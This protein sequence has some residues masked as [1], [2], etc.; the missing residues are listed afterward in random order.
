MGSPIASSE[1]RSFPRVHLSAQHRP[2]LVPLHLLV[3]LPWLGPSETPQRTLRGRPTAKLLVALLWVWM[4]PFRV[5]SRLSP[6][7][8]ALNDP[9]SPHH[10]DASGARLSRLPS[11]AA[12][13]HTQGRSKHHSASQ[14]FRGSAGCSNGMA[15]VHGSRSP[16]FC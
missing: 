6:L 4:K 16:A 10:P 13:S 5:R 9:P 12:S 14:R 2:L 7:L 15:A 1:C 11:P 8:V 3:C